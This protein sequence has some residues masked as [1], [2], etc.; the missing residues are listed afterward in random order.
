[1]ND[2]NHTD[3]I[4]RHYRDLESHRPGAEPS[5]PFDA[6]AIPASEPVPS[7]DRFRMASVA[8]F[9]A[10]LMLPFLG[11]WIGKTRGDAPATVCSMELP[12]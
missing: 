9:A 4:D 8:I 5:W 6:V 1:M 3:S 2:N 12:R 7:T 10:I 11:F